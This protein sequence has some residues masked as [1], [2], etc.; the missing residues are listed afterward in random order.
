MNFPPHNCAVLTGQLKNFHDAGVAVK[1]A[2]ISKVGS[3]PISCEARSRDMYGRS[4]SKCSAPGVGD[5][6]TWL[7]SNGYAVAY[8]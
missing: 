8:R 7:V 6:G 4:V 1:D 3:S 5:L 2:L